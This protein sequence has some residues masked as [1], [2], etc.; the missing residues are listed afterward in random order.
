MTGSVLPTIPGTPRERGV[1][2]VGTPSTRPDLDVSSAG[3]LFRPWAQ[4]IGSSRDLPPSPETSLPLPGVN[5]N[6]TDPPVV[7]PVLQ[8][9][10]V[11]D[12][13]VFPRGLFIPWV[14]VRTSSPLHSLLLRSRLLCRD[15]DETVTTDPLSPLRV[16]TRV[17]TEGGAFSFN[18][19][20]AEVPEELPPGHRKVYLRVSTQ[21]CSRGREMDVLNRRPGSAYVRRS[22]TS[23]PETDGTDEGRGGVGCSRGGRGFTE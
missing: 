5:G 6:V 17:A 8:R 15:P 10:T 21:P 11:D 1:G 16:L 2:Y 19:T 18:P 20:R 3:G 12:R 14:L 13:P 7:L 4:G 9:G 23:L 22:S